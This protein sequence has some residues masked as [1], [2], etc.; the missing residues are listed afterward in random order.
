MR[1]QRWTITPDNP[2]R[3]IPDVFYPM[4]F[5]ER[6]IKSGLRADF[7]G[8]FPVNYNA[9][10][11][12]NQEQN[13]FGCIMDMV[14]NHASDFSNIHPHRYI[15]DSP[16]FGSQQKLGSP[17]WSSKLT[18]YIRCLHKR[19]FTHMLSSSLFHYAKSRSIIKSIPLYVKPFR[20][21]ERFI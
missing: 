15:L 4:L 2:E 13:F 20:M 9:G 7:P 12:A 11:P 1:R 19:H 8:T 21:L 5:P 14:G 3:F 6:R 17:R 16:E 18:L 10:T